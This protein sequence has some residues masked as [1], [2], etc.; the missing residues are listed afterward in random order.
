M[1]APSAIA[2]SNAAAN[3]AAAA[4]VIVAAAA[5]HR[6]VITVVDR[7][8]HPNGRDMRSRTLGE[9]RFKNGLL[10]HVHEGDGSLRGLGQGEG[11]GV[12]DGGL[13][14]QRR[15][16]GQRGHCLEVD[17]AVVPVRRAQQTLQA[18]A[19]I[20]RGAGQVAAVG[21]AGLCQHVYVML[22]DFYMRLQSEYK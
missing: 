7:H 19:Q 4:V 16:L 13:L 2:R 12:H 5:I 15:Q 17:E 21:Q 22:L 3:T 11:G 8:N 9:E 14:R 18:L 10:A 6:S 20:G 1:A